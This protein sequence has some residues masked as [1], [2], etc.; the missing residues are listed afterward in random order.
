VAVCSAL[1]RI[2][3]PIDRWFNL[4]GFFRVA[5]AD[6]PRDLG[7]FLLGVLAWRRDWFARYPARAGIAWLAVGL[8]AAAAW[9]A[10]DLGLS[11][12]RSLGD[13]AMGIVYPLWEILLCL[14]LCIGLTVAFREAADF[15]GALARYCGALG[16][17]LAAN[18]YSAYVWHP[19]LVVP[20]QMAALG[21]PLGSLAK[22]ALVTV[23]GV[24]V[25]FAW[26]RLFRLLAPARAVI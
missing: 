15:R 5:F 18:Q 6:V 11:R 8:A 13:A 2:W 14:G 7:F 10:Y 22:F 4:L 20:L 21:I 23:V 1:V 3:S 9:Y 24:A 25:V 19:L 17:W 12:L 16:K 26:S